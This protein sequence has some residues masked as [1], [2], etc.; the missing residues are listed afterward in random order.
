MTLMRLA[1][2]T[3]VLGRKGGLLAAAL[4]CS[5]IAAKA[6]SIAKTEYRLDVG[7]VV[8]ISVAGVPELRQ[9][10]AVQLDGSISYPFLGT[11]VV[12]GLPP[13]ELRA[14][15]KATL[16]SKVFRQRA[17]D[18][19]EI[20]VMIEADQITA[21]VVEYRPIYV[22]GDV[23]RP[24][25]QIYRPLMTV[26]QAVALA[27]GYDIMRFRMSNPFLE[28]AEF[29]GEYESLWTEFAKEQAHIWRLKVELGEEDSR[30][31][32]MLQDAPIPKAMIS[33]ITR[34]EM[35][36]L[37]GRQD[38]YMREKQFL[39]QGIKQADE[40]IGVLSEQSD[41]E[42]AGVQADA[43]DLQRLTELFNKGSVPMPRITDA[44][45]ALLWS[46]TRKLQTI[47]QLMT[48][49][50]QRNDFSRQLERLDDLRR[51]ALRQE[52]QDAGVKLNQVRAKLQALAEK[53]QYTS[54]V[55]SQMLRGTGSKPQI[56]IVRKGRTGREHFNA[57]EDSELQPGDVV[58]VALRPEGGLILPPQ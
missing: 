45:R 13:S 44:R 5:A 42:E 33:Q 38:D 12:A 48:T 46:S 18:G 50:K 31:Q 41:K 58:E 15:I 20:V 43:E 1:I 55:K 54:L 52:L 19:R 56:T 3:K 16:P 11:F 14:K 35:E 17:P 28:S 6:E 51:I 2:Q 36:H 40:Q 7:D 9:R 34:L 27:G 24:G 53:I 4:V 23:S 37:M 22:N 21:N 47:S 30:D 49:K 25:E 8:E 39:Q 10:V 57:E 32:K 26:H 29:R